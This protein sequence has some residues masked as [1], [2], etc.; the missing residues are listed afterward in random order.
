MVRGPKAERRTEEAREL[1]RITPFIDQVYDA[2]KI[3]TGAYSPLEGFMG[4]AELETVTGRGRL[5]DD[6]PWPMPIVLAPAGR[7]NASVAERAS[8]GDAVALLD[9]GGSPFALLSVE[10]R[11]KFDRTGVAR[12]AFGT[13]DPT[14]PN[15][16]D[17]LASGETGL[18]G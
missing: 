13:T 11:F 1:P 18:A 12:A 14:H 15:V 7:A 6:T 8:R 9:G 3:A 4:L 5:P 2:E 17:M 10:E 16:A